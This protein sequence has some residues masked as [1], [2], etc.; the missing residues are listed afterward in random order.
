MD[1]G[2]QRLFE[3]VAHKLGWD[4][5]GAL[6]RAAQDLRKSLKSRHDAVSSHE[7][8]PAE[9]KESS[10]M[11]DSDASEKEN[12]LGKKNP[13]SNKKLLDSSDEDFDQILATK[14]TPKTA[15]RQISSAKKPRDPVRILS[16]DSDDGFET[17][18]SKT[19]V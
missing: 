10:F 3:R 12:R 9:R 6:D 18:F 17:C 4:K 13:L 2:T 7:T 1:S 11:S 8:E 19:L 14:A 5:P 16:S 15:A